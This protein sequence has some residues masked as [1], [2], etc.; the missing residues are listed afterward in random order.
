MER[1][2]FEKL[3]IQELC[4]RYCLTIDAQDSEGWA[5][6]FT[7][8][9]AF[10]FDGSVIR[11]HAKLRNYADVHSRVMRCRHMTL[12][13]LY[14]VKGDEAIGRSTTVV[15]LATS[16][17]YKIF[18]TG[19]Y[20]DKLLKQEGRWLIVHRRVETDRLVSDP[21]KPV[22]LADPDVAPLVQQLVDAARILAESVD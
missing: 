5:N 7:P 13:H 12:N 9:G 18:G 8:D 3:A 17:G 11:G 15:A 2:W 16:G 20:D 4:A 14:E 21:Q 6:C 19:A 1:E 22:N 10:E